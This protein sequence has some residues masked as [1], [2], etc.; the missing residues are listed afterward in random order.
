MRLGLGK[1]GPRLVGGRL[2]GLRAGVCLV[3][4]RA[5][6][7]ELLVALAQLGKHVGGLGLE[8]LALA[9]PVGRGRVGAPSG[10]GVL[11]GRSLVGRELL[12]LRAKLGQLRGQVRDLGG[13]LLALRLGLLVLATLELHQG[14]IRLR[15]GAVRL[16]LRLEALRQGGQL[17]G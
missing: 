17:L 3:E 11:Q 9:H 7:S 6:V 15:K 4:R 16:G 14:A 2:G 10:L 1:V 5:Q 13:K 8:A 12:V